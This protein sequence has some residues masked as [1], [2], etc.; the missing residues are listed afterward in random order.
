MPVADLLARWAPPKAAVLNL[1]VNRIPFVGLRMRAYGAFG[2][3]FAEAGSGMLM[4]GAEVWS[5]QLLEFGR[6]SI[7]GRGCIVD[8]RGGIRIGDHVNIG[9]ETILMT[10]KHEVQDPDFG[11]TYEPITIGD[12][13]WIATRATVLGG[14]T[15]GEG[16]VVA[17]GA[18]VT[19]DVAPYTIVGG[20]PARP[21][22]ERTRD[23]RYRLGYRANWV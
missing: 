8:A 19:S 18:V 6:G 21:I 4:L 16:A 20:V 10:A 9:S 1:F 3:R 11:G 13:V 2:V 7:V 14:V 12:R 15:L 5:P 17:A 23:L 22:G